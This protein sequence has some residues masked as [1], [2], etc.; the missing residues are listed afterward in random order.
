MK[1]RMFLILQVK[2][3]FREKLQ[4]NL[5][6]K[7]VMFDERDVDVVAEV[8]QKSVTVSTPFKHILLKQEK[9]LKNNNNNKKGGRNYVR[10]EKS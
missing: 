8:T 2:T 3:Y 6:E 1:N 7:K 5:K 10:K 9:R 4:G